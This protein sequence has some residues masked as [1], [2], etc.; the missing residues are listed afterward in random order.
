MLDQLIIFTAKYLFLVLPVAG[1]LWFIQLP[2]RAKKEALL[3]GLVTG[4]LALALGRLAAMFFFDPRPFVAGH[5]TPLM[6]HAPDNG[7]PSDHTLL[8]S[9]IAMTVFLRNR[10]IGALLWFLVLLVGAGRIAS[11]LH[12]PI[13]VAGSIAFSI[14]AGL[15]ADSVARRVFSE[16]GRKQET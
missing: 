3:L 4:V 9:A 12:S 2:I 1:F 15:L 13:D 8:S 10:R 16:F 6:P 5:F 7:F 11:G 14:V